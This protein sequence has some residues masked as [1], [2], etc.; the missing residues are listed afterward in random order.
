MSDKL[1]PVEEK[2]LAALSRGAILNGPVVAERI[3]RPRASTLRALNRLVDLGLVVAWKAHPKD[4]Q[5]LFA[6]AA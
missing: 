1:G 3:G 5:Y 4:T 6:S 2:A